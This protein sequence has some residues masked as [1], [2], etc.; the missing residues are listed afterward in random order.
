LKFLK[1]VENESADELLINIEEIENVKDEGGPT[2]I[3]LKSGKDLLVA[4]TFPEVCEMLAKCCSIIGA[5]EPS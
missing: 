3:A 2:S 1:V 4:A 5:A